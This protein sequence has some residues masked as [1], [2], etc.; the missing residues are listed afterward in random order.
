M[1]SEIVIAVSIGCIDIAW[2]ERAECNDKPR[3]FVK[4]LSV[5]LGDHNALIVGGEND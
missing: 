1:Q 5:G 3:R 4:D 2:I